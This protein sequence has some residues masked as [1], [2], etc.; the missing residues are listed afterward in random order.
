MVML[1]NSEAKKVIIEALEKWEYTHVKASSYNIATKTGY[2]Y[3][4]VTTVL[5][6][7]KTCGVAK[8]SRGSWSLV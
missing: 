4:T 1:T 5:R 7:L 2:S 3:S 8:V 6:F